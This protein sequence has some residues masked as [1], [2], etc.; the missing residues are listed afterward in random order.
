[1]LLGANKQPELVPISIL[2]NY[3]AAEIFALLKWWLGHDMSYPPERV[4]KIF[5][6]LTLL[7]LDSKLP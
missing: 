1:M 5:H 2:S 3:L 6:H 7:R 4:D